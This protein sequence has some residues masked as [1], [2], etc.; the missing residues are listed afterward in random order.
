MF[1]SFR[2]QKHSHTPLC[3][4]LAVDLWCNSWTIASYIIFKTKSC[5]Y[6][7]CPCWAYLLCVD[8]DC[9]K[10]GYGSINWT[11][12]LSPCMMKLRAEQINLDSLLLFD[13]FNR[14]LKRH[15]EPHRGSSSILHPPTH[16]PLFLHT[17]ASCLCNCRRSCEQ[18][19][20]ASSSLPHFAEL[21]SFI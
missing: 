15:L 19:F 20:R 9:L 17:Q 12:E 1:P 8:V 6:K 21:G 4:R 2:N 14:F 7:Y 18:N 5:E 10:R 16:L 3:H 11:P 13:L